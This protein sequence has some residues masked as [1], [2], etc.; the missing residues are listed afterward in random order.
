MGIN[1]DSNLV[2]QCMLKN[3]Y[4][5]DTQ[6]MYDLNWVSDKDVGFN[7]QNEDHVSNPYG[8]DYKSIIS[9]YV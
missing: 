6:D 2:Q 7:R 5:V 4:K 1:K 3:G 9:N 8:T